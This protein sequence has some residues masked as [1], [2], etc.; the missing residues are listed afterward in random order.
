[1]SMSP[2]LLLL[3]LI[4]FLFT[5]SLSL[6]ILLESYLFAYLLFLLF[7]SGLIMMLMYFCSIILSEKHL[8]VADIYILSLFVLMILVSSSNS[9]S[10]CDFL[11][12]EKLVYSEFYKLLKYTVIPY[13]VYS[14]FYIGY[15]F[16][17]L[18]V[19]YEIVSRCGGPLRMKS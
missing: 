4:G 5:I 13:S 2:L 3:T 16:L 7:I 6:V 8:L 17:C 19:V 15:L 9:G 11:G 1:M 12:V 10:F 18:I 14:V